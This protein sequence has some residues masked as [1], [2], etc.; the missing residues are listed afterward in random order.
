MDQ[1][2]ILSRCQFSSNLSIDSMDSQL[3]LQQAFFFFFKKWTD[4]KMQKIRGNKRAKTTLKKNKVG[5]FIPLDFKIYYKVI[6]F[7]TTQC[8][9]KIYNH[10]CMINGQLIFDKRENIVQWEKRSLQQMVLEHWTFIS[11]NKY[12]DLHL[13]PYTKVNSKQMKDLKYKT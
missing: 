9:I 4:S 12:F 3:K 7:K 10:T 13:V 8:G 11:K 5:G 2:T 1:K 6:A